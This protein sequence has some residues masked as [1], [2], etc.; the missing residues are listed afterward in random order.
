MRSV[1]GHAIEFHVLL[2]HPCPCMSLNLLSKADSNP[3]L[4]AINTLRPFTESPSFLNAAFLWLPELC[5]VQPRTLFGICFLS[6]LNDL[7][8]RA[9][10]SSRLAAVY[11]TV[12]RRAIRTRLPEFWFS[13]FV[14]VL[15]H[16]RR[17]TFAPQLQFEAFATSLPW[18]TATSG[19]AA[20]CV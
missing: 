19:K 2:C 12:I 20:S 3:S 11:K 14:A 17:R 13:A 4:S 16:C 7:P 15:A 8:D 9:L 5:T 1:C 10:Q 6:R 18:K